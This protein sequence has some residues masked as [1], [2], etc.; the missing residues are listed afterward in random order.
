MVSS[1]LKII[2][3][4]ACLLSFASS[5]Q[6]LECATELALVVASSVQA[7]SPTPN[8]YTEMFNYSGLKINHMGN[9]KDCEDLDGAR[10]AVFFLGAQ[11]LMLSLCAPDV[12]TKE[13]FESILPTTL[14]AAGLDASQIEIEIFF[15]KEENERCCSK[16]SHGAVAMLVV[17]AAVG[18]VALIGTGIDLDRRSLQSSSR[19]AP[20]D[21]VTEEVAVPEPTLMMKVFLCFSIPSNF[22]KL[23]DSRSAERLGK[24]DTLDVLN[25]I[26]VMSIGWVLLGH[27]YGDYFGV[28]VL[29]NYADIEDINKKFDKTIILA[30][31]FSVDTFFWLS[32]LLM[33]FLFLKEVNSGRLNWGLV[34][35]HRYLRITPMVLF[36]TLFFWSMQPYLGDGPIWFTQSGLTSDCKDYWWTNVLY[37]NNF[38]PNGKGSFCLGQVWYLACDMQFFLLSPLLLFVYHKSKLIGWSAI[39]VLISVSLLTTGLLAGKYDQ[40]VSPLTQN[41]DGFQYIYVKPYCRVG[42]YAL[43]LATGMIIY[44]YRRFKASGEVYDQVAVAICEGLKNMVVRLMSLTVG[45]F[46]VSFFVFYQY[47]TNHHPGSDMKYNRWGDDSNVAFYTFMRVGF[48]LGLTMFI[49]PVL[50]GYLKPVAIF[51]GASVWTPLAR[52]TFAVYLIHYNFIYSAFKSQYTQI[53]FDEYYLIRDLIFFYLANVILAVPF[54]VLIEMPCMNLER[55]LLRRQSQAA[56]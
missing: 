30:G 15:P 33:A 18:V 44:S 5:Q 17:V 10:Y 7:L 19:L 51:L 27:I 41:T 12:C 36:C 52:L 11:Y 54:V 31:E 16:Y 55:L 6:N 35:L 39:G 13:D 26:R 9:Y 8:L 38:I 22:V 28:A 24:R 32:G 14:E 4:L 20:L 48:I 25:G 21:G 56:K 46:L 2:L 50:L 42:T 37:L 34:Y 40:K 3:S 43:G 45:L 53:Y 49:L 1:R 47:D 29:S 23:F